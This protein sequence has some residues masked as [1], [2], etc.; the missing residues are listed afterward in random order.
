MNIISLTINNRQP[1]LA[2]N[3]FRLAIP[4]STYSSFYRAPGVV[5]NADKDAAHA[6]TSVLSATEQVA[7]QQNMSACHPH[8]L[9]PPFYPT[10][11]PPPPS[12][13]STTSELTST[14][15]PTTLG[16]VKL[17]FPPTTHVTKLISPIT[18]TAAD[19]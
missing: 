2:T 1:K 15:T 6:P 5:H 10:F 9:T 16:P 7:R 3:A 19:V 14:P 13:L 17:L 11:F 8:P 12:S 4:Q 18:P